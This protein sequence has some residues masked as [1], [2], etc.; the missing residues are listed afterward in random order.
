MLHDFAGVLSPTADLVNLKVLGI[1][2][3]TYS[4]QHI[5]FKFIDRRP[6]EAEGFVF[7]RH[8]R[9]KEINKVIMGDHEY[10]I[11]PDF[12]YSDFCRFKCLISLLIPSLF[13]SLS[14]QVLDQNLDR[15]SLKQSQSSGHHSNCMN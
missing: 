6:L 1:L 2:V 8:L 15:T 12:P 11:C 9:K 3:F 5:S 10:V 7:L 13:D 4:V 14:W